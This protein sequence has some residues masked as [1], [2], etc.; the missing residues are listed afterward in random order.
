MKLLNR[1]KMWWYAKTHTCEA[2]TINK[3]NLNHLCTKLNQVDDERVVL[4]RQ[5][6]ND[7][8]LPL[9]AKSKSTNLDNKDQL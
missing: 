8:A 7:E 9:E 6:E 4:D 1:L 2:I 3:K 5:K